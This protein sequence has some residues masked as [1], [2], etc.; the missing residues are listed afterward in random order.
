MIIGKG[1][2]H[3]PMTCFDNIAAFLKSAKIF[4]PDVHIFNYIDKLDFSMNELVSLVRRIIGK[5]EGV[6][7]R[8]PYAVGFVIGQRV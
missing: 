8:L 4:Q 7:F 1:E 5:P 3:N 2:N 6:G